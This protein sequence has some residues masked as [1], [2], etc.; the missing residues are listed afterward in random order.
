MTQE[1]NAQHHLI[2]ILTRSLL[3]IRNHPADAEAVACEAEHV[4]NIP[5]MLKLF[6]LE[7]LNFYWE[8]ERTCYLGRA[9]AAWSAGHRSD[10]ESLGQL[11]VDWDCGG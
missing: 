8:V 11:L 4:H 3:L 2:S 1:Q 7:L 5:Q 6:K 9:P 10:W